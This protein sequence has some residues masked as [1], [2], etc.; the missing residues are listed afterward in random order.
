MEIYLEDNSFTGTISHQFLASNDHTNRTIYVALSRNQLNGTLPAELSK[1]DRLTI[2]LDDNAITGIPDVLC[3]ET[4]WMEGEV[5]EFGCDAIMCPPGTYHTEIGRATKLLGDCMT[6]DSLQSDP[7]LGNTFCGDDSTSGGGGTET[8]SGGETAGTDDPNEREILTNFFTATGGPQWNMKEN[9]LNDSVSI[10]KWYGVTCGAG[11]DSSAGHVVRLELMDNALVGSVTSDM[12]MLEYLTEIDF[13]KNPGLKVHFEGAGNS[14]LERFRMSG[15]QVDLTGID[16][17]KYLAYID[18]ADAGLTGPLPDELFNMPQLISLE[19]TANALT[20]HITHHIER[21]TSITDLYLDHNLFTGTLT[22]H[23]GKLTNLKELALSH[24]AIVGP[25]PSEL[26]KLVNLELFGAKEQKDADGTR[27][28][29]GTMPSFHASP[30]LNEIYLSQNI[31]S[32]NIP[33]NLLESSNAR[34]SDSYIVYLGLDANRFTGT[35]P[36]SLDDIKN[37]IID[38]NDNFIEAVP[39]TFCDEDNAQWQNGGVAKYGCDAILCPKGHYLSPTGR[40]VQPDKPCQKCDVVGGASFMGSTSCLSLS[41]V[42]GRPIL[43]EIYEQLG[44][45]DW[46]NNDNWLQESKEVCEWYGVNCNADKTIQSLKLNSNNL[47]GTMPEDVWQIPGLQ[48][49]WLYSNPLLDIT[50]QKVHKANKLQTLLI[51]STLV[52]SIDGLE[53]A[54]DTLEEIDLRFNYLEGEFP[55]RQIAEL[56]NL[57]VLSIANNRLSGKLNSYGLGEKTKLQ[58]LR[59]GGNRLDGELPDFSTFPALQQ[60]DLSDN[61]FE[62]TIPAVF[63]KDVKDTSAPITIDL[64]SNKLHGTVPSEPFERFDQL[65]LYLR[66]NMFDGINQQLCAKQN[67]NGGDVGLYGCDGLMCPPHSFAPTGRQRTAEEPCQKCDRPTAFFAGAYECEMHASEYRSESSSSANHRT[68]F[69]FTLV[70]LIAMTCV[71]GF[72]L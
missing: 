1:F 49:L 56:T 23:I 51:D 32:G 41:E 46:Y 28:L 4:G 11:G 67:W 58:K 42:V 21:W 63:L 34:T 44:G 61:F 15:T 65:T 8:G 20:G 25:L 14:K 64:A 40:Q 22:T 6:C 60:L 5:K 29:N 53:Q 48:T 45:D 33:D 7:S 68:G 19:L 16:E 38:I 66:G 39:D 18:C 37:L 31:L 57:K 35:L 30:N 24:N 54:S 43:K 62:G 27:T 36:E 12:Y 59:L 3:N 9:W 52:S 13:D 17:A 10:C 50:F 70:S 2:T 26:N 55:Y 47:R 69:V 72:I 71:A